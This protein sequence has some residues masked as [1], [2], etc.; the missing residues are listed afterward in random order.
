MKKLFLLILTILWPLATMADTPERIARLAEQL[1]CKPGRADTVMA[2]RALGR[3]I[4]VSVEHDRKGAL[5]H[6]GLCLFTPE[7]KRMSNRTL[8]NCVERIMLDLLLKAS[9]KERL[10]YLR[11]NRLRLMW[12]GYPLGSPQ[13]DSFS[14]ALALVSESSE[15]KLTENESGYLFYLIDHN[16]TAITLAFPKD[17][18][19]IFGTDKK[20]ED[21]R[22]TLQLALG[23]TERLQPK[24]PEQSRLKST[25]DKNLWKL[26]GQQFMIDHMRSDSYYLKDQ[27]GKVQVVFDNRY[28]L[29]SFTNLLLGLV[30]DP[31]FKVDLTQKRY[32]LVLPR[33]NVDWGSLFNTLVDKNVEC[34]AAARLIDGGKTLSGVLVMNHKNYGY[35]NMLTVN[36]ECASLF[37]DKTPELKA[38][39]FTNVP[40]NNLLNLFE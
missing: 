23:S 27:A 10:T 13:F 7:M 3:N 33:F 11:E 37:S 38:Y 40:Q 28:P 15:T 30:A 9:D 25:A 14:K 2:C 5:S 19:L 34:Y 21:E 17:R 39:L 20:E 32:G 16:E 22:M 12:E 29:E 18:E 8:C 1:P 6:L 24:L 31:A 4:S 36:A 35:I 26:N